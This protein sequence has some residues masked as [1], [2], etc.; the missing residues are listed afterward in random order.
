MSLLRLSQLNKKCLMLETWLERICQS[1]F[2]GF[3]ILYIGDYVCRYIVIGVTAI[4]K[5][6]NNE[7]THIKTTKE[8]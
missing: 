4:F 7:V 8:S 5:S 6:F 1:Y 2:I 3:P